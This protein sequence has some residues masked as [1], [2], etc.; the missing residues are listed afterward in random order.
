MNL[1]SSDELMLMDKEDIVTSPCSGF[2]FIDVNGI[3][4]CVMF[5]E[6]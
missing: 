1:I 5:H 3:V 4:K 2:C 6:R